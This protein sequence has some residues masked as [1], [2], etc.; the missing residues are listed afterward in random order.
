MAKLIVSIVVLVL[1]TSL[2]IL[3]A[4]GYLGVIAD[5]G[6][7]RGEFNFNWMP[8]W[9]IFLVAGLIA[10]GLSLIGRSLWR[11]RIGRILYMILTGILPGYVVCIGW[12]AIDEAKMEKS[13]HN[14]TQ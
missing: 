12:K 11:T 1:G 7:A 4:F 13:L 2:M 5:Y 9:A 14:D 3:P 10:I 6:E 8:D